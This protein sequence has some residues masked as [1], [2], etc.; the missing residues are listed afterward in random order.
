MPPITTEQIHAGQAVYTPKML[1]I[2]DLLVL[3][4]S[5]RWIWKCP[6]PR[7]LA[8]YDR[9]ISGNHLDVGVG[10]GYFLDRCRFPAPTPRVALMDMNRDALQ[11]AARRI[12]RYRPEIY[13]RNVLAPIDAEGAKFDSLGVNYLLHCLPGDMATKARAFD[14]L[15]PLLNPGAVVFGSTLLQGGVERSFAAQRLMAFYNSKGVFSNAQDD[16]ETLTR[17]LEKRFSAVSVETIGCAALFSATV[18][19]S[20]A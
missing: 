19:G 16:L 10:T 11:Y 13:V 18:K 8:H 2:Y 5:N 17:E 1:A 14:F 15:A 9:H 4:L 20:G 6:T 7:L 3:G 12:A